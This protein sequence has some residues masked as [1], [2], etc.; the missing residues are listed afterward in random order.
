[1]TVAVAEADLFQCPDLRSELSDLAESSFEESAARLRRRPGAAAGRA[2][3]DRIP[4]SLNDHRGG[5]PWTSFL[6]EVALARRITD[7]AAIAEVGVA[8]SLVRRLPQSF[9]APAGGAAPGGAGQ[10]HR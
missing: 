8:A 10:G 6:R 7:R 4:R 5:T 1:M 3:A 9:S 2:R